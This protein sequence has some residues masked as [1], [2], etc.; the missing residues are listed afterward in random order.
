MDKEHL[1]DIKRCIKNSD[2]KNHY[3]LQDYFEVAYI[4]ELVNAYEK[5]RD[6]LEWWKQHCDDLEMEIGEN[7]E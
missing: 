6:E 2:Y 7:H 3:R 5:L 1:E 4:D